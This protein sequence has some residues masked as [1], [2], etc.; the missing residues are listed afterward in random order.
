[1]N[2]NSTPANDLRTALFCIAVAIL[3][4]FSTLQYPASSGGFPF[5]LATYF[6]LP[7]G[8]LIGIK[9]LVRRAIEKNQKSQ[10]ER[11]AESTQLVMLTPI[12]IM[13]MI[14]VTVCTLAIGHLGFITATALLAV[15]MGL[16]FKTKILL[17]VI[18]TIFQ[19][20][21]LWWFVDFFSV[22][23]PRGMLI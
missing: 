18:Y 7:L 17:T 5:A 2:S 13:V 21:F 12:T 22:Q 11:S 3:V 10:I 6:L 19:S 23:M 9:G 8:I 16:I 15:L 20:L 1:M 14:A 4:A